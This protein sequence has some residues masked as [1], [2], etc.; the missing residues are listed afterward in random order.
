MR[1]TVF[2]LLISLLGLCGCNS[3]KVLINGEW[4]EV[5]SP[6]E[7]QIL[8]GTARATLAKN[9]RLTA[10]EREFIK[11]QEPELKIRYTGDRTGDA[12][13]IWQMPDK[14]VTLLMRG[15]IFSNT[16]QWVMKVYNK[17]P[18]VLDFSKQTDP[19]VEKK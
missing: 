7:E 9:K 2:F 19:A 15:T 12:N 17:G 5:L 3:G 6:R 13:F 16:A 8:I 10:Q 18:E 14:R 4:T 1:F 11:R